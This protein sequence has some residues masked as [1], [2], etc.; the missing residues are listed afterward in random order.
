[1][2][3]KQLR[4]GVL[5]L[6]LLTGACLGVG[7]TT[8]I[9]VRSEAVDLAFGGETPAAPGSPPAAGLPVP[10]PLP[11]LEGSLPVFNFPASNPCPKASAGAVP[12]D[13]VTS[14]LAGPPAAGIYRFVQSGEAAVGLAGMPAAP[15]NLP[16]AFTTRTIHAVA[17]VTGDP[18]NS[19]EY[20]F[21]EDP[22]IFSS[23]LSSQ[24]TT[25]YLG[26]P[27]L[28]DVA[29]TS[30][31]SGAGATQ[32]GTSVD[33]V[34]LT[35][36]SFTPGGTAFTFRSP[37]G[38]QLFQAP[39]RNGLTWQSAATDAG[40]H[41]SITFQ[42]GINPSADPASDG[43]ARIDACGTVVQAWV[44]TGT[45][46]LAGP[47]PVAITDTVTLDVVPQYGGWI[48]AEH[49]VFTHAQAGEL[50]LSGTV[51]DVHLAALRPAPLPPGTH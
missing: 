4:H 6:P 39:A 50:D 40:D 33:G 26:R 19:Q 17:A 12:R 45:L 22:G 48:A 27:H 51:V 42:G 44:V 14:D 5:L 28:G 24:L 36:L 1:M 18:T 10:L 38:V 32:Q 15:T 23:Y 25:A 8:S 47:G 2:S 34:Y 41:T 21:Q 43:T 46:V 31:A 13:P 16:S 37:V 20:M 3:L 49:H 29:P 7:S 11:S 30:P 9:N 35:S